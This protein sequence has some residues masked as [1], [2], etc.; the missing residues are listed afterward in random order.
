M[1]QV[2]G[3]PATWGRAWRPVCLLLGRC[4]L[5]GGRGLGGRLRGG[6]LCLRGW[7]L[8]RRR[9]GGRRLRGRLG[10]RGLR[11]SCLRSPRLGHGGLGGRLSGGRCLGRGGLGSGGLRGRRCLGRR[12]RSC[13]RRRLGCCRLGRRFL[14][15]RQRRILPE[16]RSHPVTR[17]DLSRVYAASTLQAVWPAPGCRP[18]APS[19]AS[20]L[21]V[22]HAITNPQ[23]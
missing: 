14:S 7:R 10:G 3:D 1:P 16:P 20:L 23:D 2:V 9:L 21:C 11:R 13:L 12:L 17:P 6:C 15:C 18:P 5:R 22:H 19:H 4:R 8:R